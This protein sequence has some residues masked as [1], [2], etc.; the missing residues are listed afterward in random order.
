[1][2]VPRVFRE[3]SIY[4]PSQQKVNVSMATIDIEV[5]A[6][7]HERR[8]TNIAHTKIY[9]IESYNYYYNFTF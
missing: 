9:Q 6:S 5:D 1:M 8:A 2:R 4:R 3:N 7:V